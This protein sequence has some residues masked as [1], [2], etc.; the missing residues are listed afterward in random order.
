MIIGPT[1]QKTTKISRVS[2]S[3]AQ[4]GNT[5]LLAPSC[6]LFGQLHGDM[7]R[8]WP[9]PDCRPLQIPF[10]IT[11]VLMAV[12]FSIFPLQP[13]Q[14]RIIC[15]PTFPF[16]P[17]PQFNIPV[18]SE[19]Y[20]PPPPQKLVHTRESPTHAFSIISRGGVYFQSPIPVVM[21]DVI[22]DAVGSARQTL[23]GEENQSSVLHIVSPLCIA[24]SQR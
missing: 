5:S 16:Q 15:H 7:R 18:G 8:C 12:F 3:S 11:M 9:P 2:F 6:W 10:G 14:T 21:D 1:L 20:T 22:L 24:A 13:L 19:K 23:G 4:Q 17:H